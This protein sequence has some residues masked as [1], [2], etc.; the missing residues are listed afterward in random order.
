MPSKT[1]IIYSGVYLFGSQCTFKINSVCY[2]LRECIDNCLNLFV[3]VDHPIITCGLL[4]FLRLLV[5]WVMN[6]SRNLSFFSFSMRH[7]RRR[8]WK[9]VE[10]AVPST[11]FQPSKTRMC[12]MCSRTLPSESNEMKR[13]PLEGSIGK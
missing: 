9:T 3:V 10:G 5:N 12:E 2:L 8:R 11:G 4:E 6:I 13:L 1:K 7:F